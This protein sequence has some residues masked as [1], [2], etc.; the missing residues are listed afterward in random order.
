M[1]PQMRDYKGVAL[2]ED[3]LR[4]HVAAGR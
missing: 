3:A 2:Y 4:A 1:T